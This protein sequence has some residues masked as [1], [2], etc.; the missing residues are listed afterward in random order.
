M[1][2]DQRETIAHLREV[3]TGQEPPDTVV[4]DIGGWEAL[5]LAAGS[6]TDDPMLAVVTNIVCRDLDPTEPASVRSAKTLVEVVAATN[7]ATIF[8]TTLDAMCES[9]AFVDMVGD[10]LASACFSLDRKSVV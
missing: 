5:D 3:L 10:Q 9:P 4:A 1:S 7:D 8:A 2:Q 6:L